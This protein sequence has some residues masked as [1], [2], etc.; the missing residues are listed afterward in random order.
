MLE[1]FA[2]KEAVAENALDGE[3]FHSGTLDTLAQHVMGV[4]CSEPFDAVKLYEEVTSAGAYRELPWEDWETV[5]DFVATGGYAL[6]TYEKF[7]R[8]VKEP[9]DGLWRVRNGQVAQRHRLNVGTIVAA[10]TLNI[11]VSSEKRS[12]PG[13]KVGE[14][15]EWYFEQL[16]PG[17]TFLFGG[18]VW[19]YLGIK[20]MDALVS[21]AV[22]REPKI[23]SW[24]GS[25]FPL[26]TFLAARVRRLI[27][28]QAGWSKLPDDVREWLEIQRL[29]SSI[30]TED[31]ML[32]ETFQ[33][34]KRCYLV[35]YPFEGSDWRTPPWP[36]S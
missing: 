30:P 26:S 13:R 21:H 16:T 32:L 29:R 19:K 33:R 3:P 8:I 23:P 1:C 10:G 12:V 27:Q 15:E 20:G 11:R 28:D 18:E 25:K 6:R 5:V 31:Q 2:A 4:A 24:G 22:D 36:C 35:C 9:K 14:A 7:A 34:G 17:D